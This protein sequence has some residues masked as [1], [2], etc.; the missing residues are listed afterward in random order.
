MVDTTSST[1]RSRAI[2]TC[3][4]ALPSCV[5][6][7]EDGWVSATLSMSLSAVTGLPWQSA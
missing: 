2:S 1:P 3:W 5:P 7:D 6:K 4:R